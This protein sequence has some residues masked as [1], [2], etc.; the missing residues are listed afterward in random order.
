L[1]AIETKDAT[2]VSPS[3]PTDQEAVIV[4]LE[5]AN[6]FD[7][8]IGF[9][10][11]LVSVGKVHN[12]LTTHRFLYR[13]TDAIPGRELRLR[14]TKPSTNVIDTDPSGRRQAVEKALGGRYR[15]ISKRHVTS[16]RNGHEQR[17]RSSRCTS[18]DTHEKIKHILE[19]LTHRCRTGSVR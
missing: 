8:S 4:P 7:R 19:Y 11:T 14:R 6:C 5:K 13:S 18:L 9:S 1:D 17:S 16:N 2:S 15:G 12:H 10:S 3:A